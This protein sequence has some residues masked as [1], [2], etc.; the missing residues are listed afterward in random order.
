MKYIVLLV[1]VFGAVTAL[2]VNTNNVYSSRP[3]VGSDWT[4][5]F[6]EHRYH[7]RYLPD[8]LTQAIQILVNESPLGGVSTWLYNM[9][10]KSSPNEIRAAAENCRRLRDTWEQIVCA[11]K[12]AEKI[13]YANPNFDVN[14]LCR[15]LALAFR[16]VMDEIGNPNVFVGQIG[17]IALDSGGQVWGHNLDRITVRSVSGMTYGYAIDDESFNGPIIIYPLSYTAVQFRRKY[18][19]VLP[20]LADF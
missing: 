5:S 4:R 1:I 11:H 8:D 16:S 13:G 17:I 12:A 14:G 6:V 19:P 3:I 20:K 2:G 15:V 18:G 10:D 9:Y 7:I